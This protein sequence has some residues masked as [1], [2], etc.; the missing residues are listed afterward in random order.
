MF[1]E[2]HVSLNGY[3]ATQPYPGETRTGVKKVSMRVAWTPRWLDQGTN[4]WKDADTS[5][6]TVTCYRK[7]AENAATCVRKGDPIVVRGKLSVRQYEDKNGQQ[8]TT[9]EIDALGLGHDLNRGVSEFRRVRPQTG[10]TAL[11]YQAS[12][13]GAANGHGGDAETDEAFA[14]IVSGATDA[15]DEA[16]VAGQADDETFDEAAVGALAEEVANSTASS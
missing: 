1:N 14:S 10:M 7:L 12:G 8:R 5:F 13:D 15:D 2:V 4:E 3:V 11:E 6:V 16:A 9:V